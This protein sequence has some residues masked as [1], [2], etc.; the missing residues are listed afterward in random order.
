[1]SLA[2]RLFPGCHEPPGR[3]A[4]TVSP[5]PASESLRRSAVHCGKRSIRQPASSKKAL[6]QQER[7][8]GSPATNLQQVCTNSCRPIASM[9]S[10]LLFSSLFQASGRA[11]TCKP[12]SRIANSSLCCR[13]SRGSLVIPSSRSSR[14]LVKRPGGFAEIRAEHLHDQ[15]RAGLMRRSESGSSPGSWDL[16]NWTAIKSF[17]VLAGAATLTD[18]ETVRRLRPRLATGNRGARDGRW[19]VT[20]RHTVSSEV[21]R[22]TYVAPSAPR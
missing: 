3:T 4:V 10:I 14:P 7:T 13:Y 15:S 22:E 1:M 18:Y 2:R 6:P 21:N 20:E 16:V 8:T 5:L 11:T 19:D 9:P 17:W 12:L